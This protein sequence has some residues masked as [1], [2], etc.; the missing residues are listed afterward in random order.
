MRTLYSVYWRAVFLQS[1][2][3]SHCYTSKSSTF[4]EQGDIQPKILYSYRVCSLWKYA[5]YKIPTRQLEANLRRIERRMNV[6]SM[7]DFYSDSGAC[8]Q[9]DLVR[10]PAGLIA[11]P[12]DCGSFYQC[13]PSGTQWI[14][15]QLYCPD[16]KCYD[17]IL[18]VC[19]GFNPLCPVTGQ[20][21][22]SSSTGTTF[23]FISNSM[24]ISTYDVRN[25]SVKWLLTTA[26]CPSFCNAI[27]SWNKK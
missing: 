19:K 6:I 21:V 7:R 13:I 12:C 23:M 20:T 24:S 3:L 14:V 25:Y 16:C 9:I 26:I 10:N 15:K 1:V 5:V 22:M 2:L 18:Q 17:P 27:V 8:S 11:D 4:W